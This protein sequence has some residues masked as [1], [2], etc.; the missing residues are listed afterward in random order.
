MKRQVGFRP[1]YSL[2]PGLLV[3]ERDDPYLPSAHQASP[4]CGSHCH[5]ENPAHAVAASGAHEALQALEVLRKSKAEKLQEAKEFKLRLEHLK[6]HRNNADRL[7]KEKDGNTQRALEAQDKI[8]QLQ[9]DIEARADVMRYSRWSPL[10]TAQR[11][12]A[13]RTPHMTPHRG[14]TPERSP[15]QYSRAGGTA[16]VCTEQRLHTRCIPDV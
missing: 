7:R 4:L 6:T 2:L 12:E 14:R 1:A 15:R 13:H 11:L 3:R 5:V 10:Q 16:S 9:Q 8:A